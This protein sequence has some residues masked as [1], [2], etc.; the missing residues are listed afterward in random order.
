MKDLVEKI[1]IFEVIPNI[2]IVF[3]SP[4]FPH[5]L[6]CEIFERRFIK[7]NLI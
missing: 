2:Q 6:K 4:S 5:L 1:R 7:N 3:K